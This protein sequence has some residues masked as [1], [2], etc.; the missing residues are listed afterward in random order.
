MRK[1]LKEPVEWKDGEE[2]EGSFRAVFSTFNVI[3]LDEDITMPGAFEDGTEVKVCSWGHGWDELNVGKGVISSDETKAW[4]DGQFYLDTPHGLAH[5]RTVKHNG[6]LQEWSYGFDITA[7]S[8]REVEG[9]MVRVLEKVRVHEVSPVMKGAGMGTHTESI[10]G[11]E[12]EA[13][14]ADLAA[15]LARLEAL[16]EGEMDEA[17]LRAAYDQLEV[18]TAGLKARLAVPPPIIAGLPVNVLRARIRAAQSPAFALG[19]R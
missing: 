19:R 15:L 10:K 18:L 8:E 6:G 7:R 17:A 5:Y 13:E 9:R 12:E 2:A 1:A 3:D 16:A 14:A 4:I 11:A